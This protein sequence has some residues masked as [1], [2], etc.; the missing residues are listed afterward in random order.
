MTPARVTFVILA[1]G[2]G[3][4][5]WPLVRTHRPKV[6]VPVDGRRPLLQA[7]LDRLRA[8]RRQARVL[9]VTTAQQAEQVRRVLPPSL[10]RSVL[11]EPEGRNTAACIA[12]AASIL[13]EFGID[14]FP[15][16]E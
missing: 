15:R 14:R 7:T 6:C 11:V 16:E 2:Q 9:V 13:A 12:L 4:R 3:E 10:R 1:G 5:L 8:L